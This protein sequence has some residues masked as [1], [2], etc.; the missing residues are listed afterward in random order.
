M[1]AALPLQFLPPLQLL[2]A[3]AP[4]AVE[5]LC[6]FFYFAEFVVRVFLSGFGYGEFW[7]SP[8]KLIG[9]CMGYRNLDF[10]L[11]F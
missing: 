8:K 10:E 7:S 11:K 2:K 6:G 4:L 5:C 1:R 3:I 9:F